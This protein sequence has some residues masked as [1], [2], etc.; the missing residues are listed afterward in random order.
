MVAHSD[1]Q[2]WH[3]Y[4]SCFQS[5]PEEYQSSGNLIVITS[6]GRS[7]EED[8][9]LMAKIGSLV[10]YLPAPSFHEME[11]MRSSMWNDHTTKTLPLAANE[12][13]EKFNT[14]GDV[15]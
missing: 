10:L 7:V 2:V 8:M 5:N 1:W 11:I 15:E 3:I 13:E 6:S 14:V 9:K 4:Y 12:S